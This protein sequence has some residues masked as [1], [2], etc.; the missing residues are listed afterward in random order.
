MHLYAGS[1]AM[2]YESISRAS[3]GLYRFG[4]HETDNR[5]TQWFRSNERRAIRGDHKW[6]MMERI[7]NKVGDDVRSFWISTNDITLSRYTLERLVN[8][9]WVTL[10]DSLAEP[11]N[12]D[13]QIMKEIYVNANKWLSTNGYKD[14]AFKRAA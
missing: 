13:P 10:I 1:L 7:A 12:L 5:F 9:Q 14:D 8:N 6:E 4:F 11:V 3:A 2:Y